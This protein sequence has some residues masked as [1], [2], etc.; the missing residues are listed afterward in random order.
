MPSLFLSLA[1]LLGVVAGALSPA[2][3]ESLPTP[4]PAAS[5]DP[6]AGHPW[7]TYEGPQ[8]LSW[9]P[10]EHS[11]GQ[12]RKLLGDIAL[13]PKAKWFGAWIPNAQIAQRVD[14]YITDAQHGDPQTL[15]QMTVFR[16]VP[17][18][19]DACHRLPTK[20]ERS[21]Y[22]QWIDRF[23]TAVG[24]AY[25]AI[26]LQPDGPF[27]LCAPHGS[28]V[29]SSLVAYAARR[30]S[31][32]P[33]AT[34]YVEAGAADWPA[35]GQGGV[36]A[37]VQILLRGGIRYAHGF[38]LDSTHY[39]STADEI[40][41][42][43]AIAT[44]LSSL[45]Y[46]GRKAV[47]NTSG[48]GHPWVFGDYTGKDPDNPP[49]CASAQAP[50]GRTCETLGIPPTARVGAARWGLAPAL[51]R[52]ARRYVDAYLWVGRPWLYNGAS[53]FVMKRALQLVRST[54]WR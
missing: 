27:A 17:W 12:R 7:G 41:R 44:Q 21:S 9:G 35:A 54:P 24:G 45:G 3:H 39:D 5:S 18:E 23:A 49:V 51:R 4:S 32:Q 15:V 53:P 14:D 43:K 42:A 33:H 13:T 25:A 37:A 19:Q 20:A 34:V 52:Q 50:A 6:L 40:R 28:K 22:K 48:N 36:D 29:P 11:T 16:M 8:E 1:M 47:I 26:V 10:Y 31:A 46:P 38:A 2:H 30:L